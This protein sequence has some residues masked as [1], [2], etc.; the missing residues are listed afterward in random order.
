MKVRRE[1]N[2]SVGDMRFFMARNAVCK[3]LIHI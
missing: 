3:S 2:F 1:V